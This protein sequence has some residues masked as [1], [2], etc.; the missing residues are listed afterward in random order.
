M[1]S[2]DPMDKVAGFGLADVRFIVKKFRDIQEDVDTLVN[3]PV[4]DRFSKESVRDMRSL[5]RCDEE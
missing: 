3:I 5:A 2:A 1:P 4:A